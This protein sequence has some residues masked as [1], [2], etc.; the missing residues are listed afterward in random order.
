MANVAF[1]LDLEFDS[2]GRIYFN[3]LEAVLDKLSAKNLLYNHLYLTLRELDLITIEQT[4]AI[5]KVKVGTNSR[6]SNG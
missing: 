4:S 6:V 1:T 3:D 2:E 5:V